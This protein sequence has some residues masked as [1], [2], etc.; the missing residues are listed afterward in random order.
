MA[1]RLIPFFTH[2]ATKD[3]ILWLHPVLSN[4]LALVLV[5]NVELFQDP[6]LSPEAAVMATINLDLMEPLCL[7]LSSMLF[8]FYSKT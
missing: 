3:L 8:P 4:L 5:V 2:P 6:L 7:H 1:K